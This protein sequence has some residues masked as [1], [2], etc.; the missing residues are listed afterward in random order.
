[1]RPTC[2]PLASSVWRSRIRLCSCSFVIAGLFLPLASA[3]Q[4]ANSS[5]SERRTAKKPVA[6]QAGDLQTRLAALEA[7]KQSGEASAVT[8]AA[9]RV[10]ALSLRRIAEL[11]LLDTA[12]SDAANILS[13]SI[14]LED[15]PATHTDLASAYILGGKP[16]DALSHATNSVVADPHNARGWRVQGQAWLLKK[17]Y[18][19]AAESLKRSGELQADAYTEYLLGYALLE[20]QQLEKAQSAFRRAFAHKSTNLSALH[21]LVSDAYLGSNYLDD[22]ALELKQA[23]A[24]NPKLPHGHC[25]SALLESARTDW[26]ISPSI[27]TGLLKEVELNPRDFFGNYALGLV[28]FFDQDYVQAK[29]SLERAR[30]ARPDWPDAWLY[31]GLSA[32][33]Q[34]D[35]KDAEENLR[36]AI[37]LT[38]SD[39]RGNYQIRRA[40]YTLGRLF[41]QQGRNEEAT[42]ALRH[43]REIQSKLLLDAQRMPGK[44]GGGMAQM[45]QSAAAFSAIVMLQSEASFSLPAPEDS[46][47]DLGLAI[48]HSALTA[49]QQE[50]IKTKESELRKILSGA[51]NDLGA[52]EARQERFAP[53][54]GYFHE[55][56][57]WN[58]QTPGL[59]RNMGMAAARLSDYPEA[60]RALRSVVAANSA[61][62]VARSLLG[63]ALF[64]IDHYTEAASVFS[65]LDDSVLDRPELAYAWASS[66]VKINQY[67]Q[68][69]ALL[70][71]LSQ[72]PLQ[73][74]TLILIAQTWSQMGNYPKTVEICQRALDENSKL[75]RAHYIAGLAL[76]HQDRPAEAAKEF[77]SELQLD[78]DNI[79]AQ[80][81]LA[82]VLLQ[83][84]QNE[85][86]THWLRS[87]L[88]RNPEHPEANYELGKQLMSEGKL[89]DAIPY[90]EAAARLK[91]QFEPGHYQLQSAYRASGRKEDADRE[92]KIY[93]ELKAKSR[94]ITL[95]PPRQQSGEPSHP[96]KP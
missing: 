24:L 51:L 16:D 22:A 91:P 83:L 19:G 23:L 55:A 9:R 75:P 82:F 3:T 27:R 18:E 6:A 62:T 86:A 34:G 95:P 57:K 80:F 5:A 38:V 64:A 13:R 4:Q 84:S 94:N 54:L 2:I 92:A 36:K 93:R 77:R 46:A 87:V 10:A 43:F 17:N 50:S 73:A 48:D 71:K 30:S 76:I 79:E 15:V 14:D 65:A 90:L 66:L 49:K 78:S 58:A 29:A 26:A 70:T 42:E 1:V 81:H 89:D 85:E 53:A 69:S 39:S 59:M 61:D 12:I 63:L 35:E 44:M 72:R 37:A 7:A 45:S 32:Y 60:A 88:A 41:T 96:D 74:E 40:Y 21:A 56:E 52:V 25:R 11:S 33:S 47:P 31:L 8:A 28:K 68:A 67:P 20:S